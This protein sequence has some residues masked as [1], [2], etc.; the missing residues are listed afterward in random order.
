[1]DLVMADRMY[2]IRCQ[3]AGC[4]EEY[5]GPDLSALIGAFA[6]HCCASHPILQLD[7]ERDPMVTTYVAEGA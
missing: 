4:T 5:F 7:S 1:V 3:Q 6:T 2:R